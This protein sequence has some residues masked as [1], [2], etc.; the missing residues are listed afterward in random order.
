VNFQY[1]YN[2]DRTVV[3]LSSDATYY[4]TGS[5]K[6][7]NADINVGGDSEVWSNKVD[8]DI[9]LGRMLF[10]HELRTGGYLER[11]GLFGNVRGGL[12]TDY[13]NEVHGR[14]VLDYLNELWLT[15]WIGVGGSYYWGSNFTGWSFGIDFYL[16]F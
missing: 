3:T 1:E 12:S 13:M 16:V 8:I 4:H 5:L 10:G 2:W 14:L 15:Q 9:P 11:T 6:S 7:S